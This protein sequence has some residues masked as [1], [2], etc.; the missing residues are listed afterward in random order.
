MARDFLKVRDAFLTEGAMEL[1]VNKK[2]E[3][4]SENG[5]CPMNR[6]TVVNILLKEYHALLKSAKTNIPSLDD[7]K[8]YPYRGICG[9]CGSYKEKLDADFLCQDC[10]SMG[11][12]AKSSN[13][14]D[15]FL[16]FV[17]PRF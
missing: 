14:A 10:Y 16:R 15:E 1:V 3:L 4:E 2:R 11:V 8:K 13:I 5:H 12:R 9:K 7:I 17:K 6:G